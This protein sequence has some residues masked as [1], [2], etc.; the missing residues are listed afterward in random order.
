MIS[1]VFSPRMM[2]VCTA[3][4]PGIAIVWILNAFSREG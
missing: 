3:I 4:S 2:T 1:G